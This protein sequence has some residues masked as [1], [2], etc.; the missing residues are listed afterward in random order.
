MI[1]VARGLQGDRAG[2]VPD[3]GSRGDVKVDCWGSRLAARAARVRKIG[4]VSCKAKPLP[5]HLTLH[6]ALAQGFVPSADGTWEI[7]ARVG[8]DV[9]AQ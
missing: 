1:T 5:A 4:A 8:L 9:T 2:A 7:W 3:G 6:G